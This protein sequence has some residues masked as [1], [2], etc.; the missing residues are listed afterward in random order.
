MRADE[1]IAQFKNGRRL[2]PAWLGPA[3]YLI[4]KGLFYKIAL[5]D[6]AGEIVSGAA[7]TDPDVSAYRVLVFS[8]A[9]SW[10]VFFDFHGYTTIARGSARLFG[11]ELARNFYVPFYAHGF[12]DHWRRWH[13]TLSRWLREYL[14]I[15]LGGN[16]VGPARMYFNIMLTMLL[17]GLWHGAGWNYLLWGGLHGVYLVGERLLGLRDRRPRGPARFAAACLVYALCVPAFGIFA[18]DAVTDPWPIVRSLA[19]WGITESLTLL[20]CALVTVGLSRLA[21]LFDEQTLAA[22]RR[23]ALLLAAG[24]LLLLTGC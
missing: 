17:G 18:M 14:Y 16:R 1:L 8:V 10:Q 4:L 3:S 12:A 22:R 2:D 7:I 13:V 5:A 6:R 19:D 15:G 21:L 24:M 23:P 20:V 11:I 9:F